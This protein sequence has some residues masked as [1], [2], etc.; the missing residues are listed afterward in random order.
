[1]KLKLK[2]DSLVGL[3]ID[4]WLRFGLFFGLTFSL[5]GQD[6]WQQTQPALGSDVQTLLAP[7]DGNV[8]AGTD[9]SGVYKKNSNSWQ[10]INNNLSSL[11]INDMAYYSGGFV[12]AG[13][14]YHFFAATEPFGVYYYDGETWEHRGLLGLYPMA[15]GTLVEELSAWDYRY[16]LFVASTTTGVVRSTDSGLNWSSVGL[17]HAGIDKLLVTSDYIFACGP[18]KDI[19]RSDNKGDIWTKLDTDGITGYIIKGILEAIGGDIYVVTDEDP[20]PEHI[21]G[22]I[23]RADSHGEGWISCIQSGEIINESSFHLIAENSAGHLFVSTGSGSVFR[24]VDGASWTSVSSG[25]DGDVVR[26]LTV[27]SHGFL[28]AGVNDKVFKSNVS[29]LRPLITDETASVDATAYSTTLNG[30]VNPCDYSTDVTFEY[31]TSTSYDEEIPS[32]TGTLTGSDYQ[33]VT[34]TVTGLLPNQEYHWRIAAT[35][36]KGTTDGDDQTF[37][38]AKGPDAETQT[39]ITSEDGAS[40]K[41]LVHPNNLSTTVQFE[42]GETESLGNTVSAI[43]GSVNGMENT[44]VSADITG[45]T[46]NQ[47]YFYRITATNAVGID[48]GDLVSFVLSDGPDA[49][50]QA[51]SDVNGTSATL[52]GLVNPKNLSTDVTFEYGLTTDYGE[53]QAASESPVSGSGEIAVSTELSGLEPNRTYHYRVATSNTAG[54]A[55]GL[56]ASFTTFRPPD[57]VTEAPSTASGSS[58]V[59]NGRIHPFNLT[60]NVFFEWGLTE[61]YGNIVNANPGTVDGS[62]DTSVSAGLSGLAINTTYH[63]RVVALYNQGRVEGEDMAFTHITG[64]VAAPEFSPAP[65]I[66][67]TAQTVAITCATE[68]A[69][70]HF[71][72]DGSDPDESDPAIGSGGTVYLS[73]TST[74]KAIACKEDWETSEIASGTYTITGKVATPVFSPEAGT[75]SSPQ[76]VTITCATE[77]A[78]IHFTTD[79]SDPDQ[80]DSAISSGGTVYLSATATLKA[81]ACKDGWEASEITSAE[82][83]IDSG[84]AVEQSDKIPLQ[85]N[86][87][88]NFPN[89]FNPATVIHFALPEDTE[90]S[91]QVFNLLGKKIV[92]L[93]N[94]ESYQAGTYT[95]MWNGRDQT[96]H[97]VNNG[98]Y[99]YQLTAGSYSCIK[100][101]SFLK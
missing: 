97:L 13:Q 35:N 70:I 19:Y 80:S 37:T 34:A 31:G 96:G 52:N 25:L 7:P 49:V 98:V 1:M 100:K 11:D 21:D 59:L 29:T 39:P 56:D 54:N 79:G 55:Q 94:H 50:T 45:L 48:S 89:P 51:A 23:F 44:P 2:L 68:G 83:T 30:Q 53:T 8:Y 86:L 82:Y 93:V 38:I 6:F 57:V 81:I 87:S 12:A 36:S 58:V 17:A 27:D 4:F 62:D 67:T 14:P 66:Y 16:Y 74:L 63:Y 75:Y 22:G 47:T 92:T 76:D 73:K 60:A 99:L 78:T 41:G 15:I 85:F 43:P 90:V 33:D 91:L 101:A 20:R 3:N 9:Y 26:A 72:M 84:S 64:K 88:Q 42:W 28:Y 77:G 24:S 61:S 46:V 40:L 5:N 71:T 95:A 65:G 10:Q 18:V 69:A 32:E